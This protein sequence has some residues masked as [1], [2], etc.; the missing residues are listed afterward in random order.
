MS[1]RCIEIAPASPFFR[2]MNPLAPKQI[3]HGFQLPNSDLLTIGQ[4]AKT[5]GCSGQHATNLISAEELEAA[6]IAQPQ[7]RKEQRIS[8][9]SLVDFINRRTTGS[10]GDFQT[11]DAPIGLDL[12]PGKILGVPA[13]SGFLKC[14][15][16]HALNLIRKEQI[17]ATNVARSE[18]GRARYLIARSSLI[19]FI[20]SRTEGAY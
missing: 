8:R 6:N 3:L 9:T 18:T 5:L 16:Q 14:T 13:I 19:H 10:T 7:K 4:V 15:T 1:N 11:L 12:P 2:Q 20:K 17:R